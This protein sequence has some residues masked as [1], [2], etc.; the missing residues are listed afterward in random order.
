MAVLTRR[1][2]HDLEAKPLCPVCLSLENERIEMQVWLVQTQFTLILDYLMAYLAICDNCG[3]RLPLTLE[4][5]DEVEI[6]EGEAC[7]SYL[8]RCQVCGRPP[9]E[10][11]EFH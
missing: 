5:A 2:D 7:A 6:R 9:D 1:A 3:L 4:S 10:H 11:P 8:G